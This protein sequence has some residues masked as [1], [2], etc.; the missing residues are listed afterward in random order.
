MASRHHDA[1][2]FE[3]DACASSHLST[4]ARAHFDVLMR[5]HRNASAL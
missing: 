5:A 1:A 2:R 4:Y 3:V